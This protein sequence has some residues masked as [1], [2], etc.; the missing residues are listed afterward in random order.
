MFLNH[1]KEENFLN[2]FVEAK[3]KELAEK[4]AKE[5]ENII[6]EKEENKKNEEEQEEES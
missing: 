4:N 5:S 3:K 1:I 6:E 2:T